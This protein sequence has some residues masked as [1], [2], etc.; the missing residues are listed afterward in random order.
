MSRGERPN[1]ES[2]PK[3]RIAVVLKGYPR[4]SET[5]IAQEILS[6][7]TDGADITIVSL[8]HPTDG[9]THPVHDKIKAP[10]LYLPEYLYQELPRV[11]RGWWQSRKQLGYQAA[12]RAWWADLKRDPTPNRIRRWGQALVLAAE[13]DPAI[14]TLYAHFLHTPGSVARYAAGITRRPWAVSAHAKDIWLT[15]EWEKREKLADCAWAV[16]C[17]AY[18]HAHL[19]SL[20]PGKTTLSYHGLDLAA[21]PS[22]PATRPPRRGESK[23]DAIHLV[24]VGRAVPK[25]GFDGLLHALA[26]LPTALHW[27]WTHIG[28]GGELA[29]LKRQAEALD[30]SEKITWKGARA[31][32]EVFEAYREADLFVLP[33]RIAED[34]DRDGLPNVLMEAA[35]QGLCCLASDVAGVSELLTHGETGW[36]TPAD[37]PEAL[38]SAITTLAGD[39]DQRLRLGAAGL[40]RVTRCFDHAAGLSIIRERLGIPV[41][42]VNDAFN[43]AD[44][45]AAQ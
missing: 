30:I 36:L 2:F 44:L 40:D 33:S 35:S 38:A 34:G 5:F 37:D 12:R 41:T 26:S 9:K 7:E 6:L 10:V 23:D 45:D 29:K 22:P 18:G 4:L 11:L 19:E 15:P 24:S 43:A 3:P 14:S 16:T 39:P 25:K 42:P 20:G 21:L 1:P 32:A 13:L 8:R 27:T 17:T 28:G 31:Q